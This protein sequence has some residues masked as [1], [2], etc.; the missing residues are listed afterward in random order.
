MKKR[1]KKQI[2]LD[3]GITLI[4]ALLVMSIFAIIVGMASI[5]LVG[6]K[7]SPSSWASVETF[8][9][10]LKQQQLKAMVGDTQGSGDISDY[11]IHFETT[12]YTLFRGTYVVSNTSNFVVTLPAAIQVSTGLSGSQ[13]LFSK[14]TGDVSN[15]DP[16]PANNYITFTDTTINSQKKITVNKH[17]VINQ[18]Q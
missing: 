11:G 9:A 10:D 5:N 3:A 17:G 14:L 4:E 1:E 13:I 8:M 2:R 15:Y 7:N 6:S 16:V 18:I 12:T